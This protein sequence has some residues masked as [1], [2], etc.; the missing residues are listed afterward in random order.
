MRS[1]TCS[2]P[3][4]TSTV[5]TGPRP[6]SSRA[7]I[8][9]PSA[10]RSGLALRSSNS[11]CSAINSSSLSRLIFCVAETSTSSVSPPSDFDLNFIL[12]QLAAHPFGLGVR[13]VDLVDRDDHRHMR[14]ARMG[15]RLDRLRHDAVIGRDDEHDDIRHLGAAGAHR[16]EGG[17]AGRIDEG[18]RQAVRRRDLIGADMLGDAAGFA[19]DDIG[20]ADRIEQRGLAVIDMAHDGDDGRTRQQM[21]STSSGVS[22]RPSSTSDFGDAFHRVAEFLRDELRGIGVDH[23]GDLRH[24]ALLHQ[25]LDDVDAAFRHAVGEFLD[26][27]RLRQDRLRATIFSFCSRDMALEPLRAAAEGRDR[28]RAL[29]LLAGR[30]GN[31]QAAAVLLLGAARRTRHDDFGRERRAGG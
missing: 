28:T 23:V 9:V 31:G 1:P 6:R 18:H 4:W 7:S 5:A 19:G 11:A 3:R 25:K 21:S 24:L 12:Q 13:L 10:A 29:I 22:N 16:R 26:G 20:M 14:G 27:D 2:V 17:V 8:T 15:D 30:A